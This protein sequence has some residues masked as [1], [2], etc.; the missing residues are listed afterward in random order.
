MKTEKHPDTNCLVAPRILVLVLSFMAVLPVW[1]G[2][3]LHLD[4]NR[5]MVGETVTLTFVTDDSRQSLEADFSMLEQDFEILDRRSETQ[6]SIVN[7]RQ[8]ATVRLLLTI[9][10]KHDGDI[11]IPGFSFGTE[12]TSP[13]ML[14]VDPAPEL[15]PGALPPV[16]IEVELTPGEEPYYVHAQFGLVVRVFYQQNLTEAAISQ[17]EPNPASVRLLQETPYQAERGGERYRVLERHYAIFPERSGELVIPSMELSGRL[18]ERRDNGIWQSNVRGRRVR[19]VSDELKLLIEPR[20]AEFSGSGW[21]PARDLKVAQ[22]I[23]SGEALR[24]GEPVTRTVLVD[25]VGLEENM[26]V[27]PAWPEL[28]NA[29]IYPD[30]PQGI[31]RD[32]GRWVLG[33]KEFRYA[34]VP[35]Q[36][37]ELVL[38]ELRVDWWDTKNNAQR[39]AIL[40]AHTLFVQ[41][42][43]LVPSAVQTPE[44]APP[45]DSGPVEV[46]PTPAP[47]ESPWKWLTVLFAVLW[48]AT[49][50]LAWRL[51]VRR[52][53]GEQP[54]GTGRPLGEH[55]TALL[56]E[57]KRACCSGDRG[58]ARRTLQ[59]WLR[60]YGQDGNVSILEFAAT[61]GDQALLENLYA[62]DSDGFRRDNG[63]SWSGRVFWRQFE[64][65]RK[66]QA[67]S[68]ARNK[69]PLTDLYAPE[70][71]VKS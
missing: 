30:Q 14:R 32:D 47:T 71:R 9:E 66:E 63:V 33:H 39:T 10:P 23:S 21:Q 65:W 24:V 2:V 52:R 62:L 27:E 7:G 48:I 1:A 22:K 54:T 57:L 15:E 31:T 13:A 43:I 26:I 20:P 61:V 59:R 46:G 17:P 4:R 40:P 69:P 36:E 67:G 16:F 68:V 8:T 60:D 45:Q 12:K 64:N 3:E 53:P 28:E 11:Q 38:P 56:K 51:R 50:L 55:E 42:S 6:L 35:E 18:V 44:P 5:L 70:N 25:A 49:L 34:V 19:A 37:G 41:P 29:R 58:T